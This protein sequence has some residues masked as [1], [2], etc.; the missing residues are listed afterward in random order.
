MRHVL[1]TYMMVAAALAIT[2][3]GQVDPGERAV[4]IRWGVIAE[5]CFEEGFYFYDPFGTNMN[6][7]DV[8]VQKHE[9]DAASKDLQDVK[10]DVVLNFSLDGTKCHELYKTVGSDFLARVV[11]PAI[12]E[13]VKA[14]SATFPVEKIIQERAKLKAQ[15][16]G[17][18]RARLEPYRISVADVALVNISFSEGFTHAVEAKQVEEQNVQKAEY[19]RQQAL[20]NAESAVAKAEGEARAN[21]L[22]KAQL[23]PELLQYEAIMKWNGVLPAVTGSGGTPLLN[24]EKFR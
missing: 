6:T 22:K 17:D 13:T 15:I 10:M 2:G 16:V 8:K 21:A 5:R 23:T 9:T 7:I 4:F 20:K 11:D 18:L 3:C 12:V 19:Q 14:A 1:S 24:L